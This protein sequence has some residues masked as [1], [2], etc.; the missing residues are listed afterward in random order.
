MPLTTWTDALKKP[1]IGVFSFGKNIGDKSPLTAQFEFDVASLRDP[2][3]Q[4]QFVNLN[5]TFPDVISWVFEDRRVPIIIKDCLLLADDLAKPKLREGSSVAKP[6]GTWL[7]FSFRDF[8]G[9]W[10]AP[11]VAEK[12]ADALSDAGYLVAVH[13][14]SLAK[15]LWYR[16]PIIIPPTLELTN[17]NN[18][19]T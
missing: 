2:A 5:G 16:A 19:N 11:A 17:V 6:I 10:I 7:S 14:Q 1:E 9:K 8:H 4:K 15:D 3:G 18:I 12:V 13:H